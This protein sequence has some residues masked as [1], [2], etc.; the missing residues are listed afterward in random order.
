[1]DRLQAHVAEFLSDHRSIVILSQKS[2]FEGLEGREVPCGEVA[3]E[4]LQRAADAGHVAAANWLGECRTKGV[5]LKV[6]PAA[7]LALFESATES[8]SARAHINLGFCLR[9]AEGEASRDA[10]LQ[11]LKAA[12]QGH[13]QACFLISKCFKMGQGIGQNQKKALEFLKT[14]AS[15]NHCEALYELGVAHVK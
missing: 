11:F 9:E 8:G 7:A 12:Q 4:L 6:D 10:A 2:L 3:V 14:A 13:P 1:M 15:L 5:L